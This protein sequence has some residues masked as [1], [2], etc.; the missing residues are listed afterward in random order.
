M[1]RTVRLSWLQL[2]NMCTNVIISICESVPL[3]SA[4]AMC[5]GIPHLA[6]QSVW[7]SRNF[8][9][10]Y[11][12]AQS[13][14][15]NTEV[16]WSCFRISSLHSSLLPERSKWDFQ[17]QSSTRLWYH[18]SNSTLP[19]FPW[20]QQQLKQ[21]ESTCHS[22]L[23]G[24]GH[25]LKDNLGRLGHWEHMLYSDQVHWSALKHAP[26]EKNKWS[27]WRKELSNVASSGNE[28]MIKTKFIQ[29]CVHLIRV[30]NTRRFEGALPSLVG[31][32]KPLRKRK[33]CRNFW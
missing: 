14:T 23:R 25:S 8:R 29:M 15:I 5:H 26:W 17:A 19:E 4:T 13:N 28:C 18:L 16:S 27:V 10:R 20:F 21:V 12:M 31:C 32:F 3:L 24:H 7:L 1:A 9:G 22:G 6:N 33:H 11:F 30:Q 2:S